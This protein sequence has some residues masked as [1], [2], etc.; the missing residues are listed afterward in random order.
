MRILLADDHVLFREAMVQYFRHAMPDTIV[1]AAGDVRETIDILSEPAAA[2]ILLLDL[3]MPG[4]NDLAGLRQIHAAWPDLPVVV[5]SGWAEESDVAQAMQLGARGYLPK[6]LSGTA[7]LDG[8]REIMAGRRF[9]AQDGGGIMPSHYD[10]KP[11]YRPALNPREKQVLDHIK[12][13]ETNKDIARALG[14]KLVTVKLHVR[15]VCRKLGAKNR[16]QAA[17]F[18]REQGC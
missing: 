7:L 17:M 12:R 3:R 13:G 14:L 11:A 6:T 10:T 1:L 9:V 2:D 16:T 8:I 18:A 15:G 5:V 4:M